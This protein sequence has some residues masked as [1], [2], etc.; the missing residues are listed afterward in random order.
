MN[1]TKMNLLSG[2]A[3]LGLEE[4]AQEVIVKDLKG[5]LTKLD[6]AQEAIDKL[7]ETV[8]AYSTL[9][10]NL[11][12]QKQMVEAEVEELKQS[13]NE[14]DVSAPDF[15]QQ[16]LEINKQIEVKEE[17]I[18]AVATGS[19][20]LG[21][22]AK[23]DT[24]DALAVGYKAVRDSN[25]ETSLLIDDVGQVVNKT[26]KAQ[27]VQAVKSIVGELNHY[28]YVLRDV[29]ASIGA[30]RVTHNGVRFSISNSSLESALSRLERI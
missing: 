3:M 14:L 16:M 19:L 30:D 20:T 21:Q 1:K 18:K 25:Y 13:I 10:A 12:T 11:T 9:S 27:I 28:Q 23:A 15:V 7:E 26:N 6:T 8:E 4:K 24:M 17:T 5:Q 29:T 22:K 2:L